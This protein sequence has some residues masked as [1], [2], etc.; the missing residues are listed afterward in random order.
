M[1]TPH[2]LSLER[3]RRRRLS[4]ISITGE[5]PTPELEVPSE[6]FK[7]PELSTEEKLSQAEEAALEL[8][9]EAVGGY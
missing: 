2:K 3:E 7:L 6:E 1:E 8:E 4:R 5:F 9:S